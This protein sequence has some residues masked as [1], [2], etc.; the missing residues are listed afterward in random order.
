MTNFTIPP[1]GML[2][3]Q[4]DLPAYSLALALVHREGDASPQI[5]IWDGGLWRHLTVQAARKWADDQEAGPYAEAFTPVIEAL[6][7]LA[8][9]VE[10]I[11]TR[12][13]FKRAGK[14]AMR[15]VK[16]ADMPVEGHA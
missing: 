4:V 10:D 13:V 8:G 6:R 5:A 16:F 1:E 9:R 14:T 7:T 12:A 15:A 11:T 2:S 3:E